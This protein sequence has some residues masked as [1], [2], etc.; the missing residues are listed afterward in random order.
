M[1]VPTK[2]H[3][4]ARYTCQPMAVSQPR[5]CKSGLTSRR[6]AQFRTGVVAKQFLPPARSKFLDPVVLT[7]GC[8]RHACHFCDACIYQRL[9]DSAGNRAPEQKRSTAINQNEKKVTTTVRYCES[10]RTGP[11]YRTKECLPNWLHMSMQS[12]AW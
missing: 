1:M 10:M 5:L 7:T 6:D 3:T 12:R 8:R 4:L 2:K 11:V 9:P